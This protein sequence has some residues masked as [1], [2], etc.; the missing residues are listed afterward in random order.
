MRTGWKAAIVCLAA[1]VSN[2]CA[3]SDGGDGGGPAGTDAG[4][5]ASSGDASEGD[6]SDSGTSDSGTSDSG[7]CAT[8]CSLVGNSGCEF[9][10]TEAECLPGCES[11]LQGT[12]AEQLRLLLDCVEPH[13][14]AACSSLSVVYFPGCEAEQDAYFACTDA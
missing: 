9:A 8:M 4:V 1:A 2:V 7:T 6:A 12:C 5:D 14:T 13:P 3:C 10:A 11:D